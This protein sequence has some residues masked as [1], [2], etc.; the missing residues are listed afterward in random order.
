MR[1]RA[2]IVTWGGIA[3]W[4]STFIVLGRRG[5]PENVWTPES[6]EEC[7]RGLLLAC[8]FLCGAFVVVGLSYLLSDEGPTGEAMAGL[9]KFA[10]GWLFVPLSIGL[11]VALL[12]R[13]AYLFL[14]NV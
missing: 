9:M 1:T 11:F 10:V 14:T 3:L 5:F 13:Y 6:N 12:L 4:I 8:N 7:L 2:K